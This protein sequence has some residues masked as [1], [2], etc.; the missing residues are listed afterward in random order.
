MYTFVRVE[1]VEPANNRAEISVRRPVL[2]RKVCFGRW[3]EAGSGYVKR[4]LTTVATLRLQERNVLDY[5]TEVCCIAIA[6]HAASSLRPT[7]T[8]A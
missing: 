3:S 1:G 2:W 8:A 5:L 4:I 7:F 6:G